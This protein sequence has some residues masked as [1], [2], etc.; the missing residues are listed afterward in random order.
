MATQK[1]NKNLWYIYRI[2]PLVT[3]SEPIK[4]IRILYH[5][6]HPYAKNNLQIKYRYK[7]NKMPSYT[8]L[9]G[10]ARRSAFK[11]HLRKQLGRKKK[12]K[13]KRKPKKKDKFDEWLKNPN[14]PEAK[15]EENQPTTQTYI[16]IRE[17]PVKPNLEAFGIIKRKRA[18]V[19]KSKRQRII[20]NFE[21]LKSKPKI[22]RRR[23]TK[24]VVTVH[25][26]DKNHVHLFKEISRENDKVTEQCSCGFHRVVEEM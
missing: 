23:L 22:K 9:E 17:E 11:S 25:T 10:E 20:D 12:K 6:W 8:V 5:H 18:K 15:P 7:P 21:G 2:V 4:Y 3:V 14:K 16:H 1:K 26:L 19:K 24:T 13:K